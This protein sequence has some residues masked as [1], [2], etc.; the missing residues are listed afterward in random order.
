MRRRRLLASAPALA[1]GLPASCDEP[2][3]AAFRA[4]DG[5]PDGLSDS[6]AYLR[7][8]FN[9]LFKPRVIERAWTQG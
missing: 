2:A 1:C 4:W 8:G 3:A 6:G 5:P 7:N 9:P